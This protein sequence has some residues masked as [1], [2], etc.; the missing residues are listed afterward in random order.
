MWTI[1]VESGGNQTRLSWL[2][3]KEWRSRDWIGHV[4]NIKNQHHVIQGHEWVVDGLNLDVGV[5]QRRARDESADAAKAVDTESDRGHDE[6]EGRMKVC[7]ARG[8]A[9]CSIH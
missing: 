6:N 8:G 2:P 7:G 9:T 3:H 4:E 5:C 1:P